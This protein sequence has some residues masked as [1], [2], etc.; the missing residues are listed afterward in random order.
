[1]IG[2][3]SANAC[4]HMFAKK[5]NQTKKFTESHFALAAGITARASFSRSVGLMHQFVH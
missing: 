3:N 1:M 2:H 5:E 4:A